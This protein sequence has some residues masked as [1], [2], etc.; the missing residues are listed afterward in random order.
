MEEPDGLSR[1]LMHDVFGDV[2]SPIP[3]PPSWFALAACGDH[4]PE[5]WFPVKGETGAEA[6]RICG[7]CP[8]R[9]LC[10]D[11]A[12]EVVDVAGGDTETTSLRFGILGGLSS[13][14]RTAMARRGEGPFAAE[15][16]AS[17]LRRAG[18]AERGERL[19]AEAVRGGV[20][21]A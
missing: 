10:L 11:Y 12:L 2:A 21:V 20:P 3:P 9:S 15:A 5:L 18:D 13:R 6:K 16:A 17:P 8:V 19:I 1:W 14:E 4:D 7:G